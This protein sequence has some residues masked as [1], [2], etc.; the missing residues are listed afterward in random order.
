ML[1]N[2]V[3]FLVFLVVTYL[4]YRVLP[5]RGQ[6]LILLIAS[7]VFYSWWDVRFLFLIILSTTVD[8]YCGAMIET[9]RLTRSR[10]C[11]ASLSVL[12]AAFSLLQSNGVRFTSKPNR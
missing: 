3:E 11:I 2:S 5:L 6:N 12:F 10:R 8:F 9:G 7:Y 1:F 4:L